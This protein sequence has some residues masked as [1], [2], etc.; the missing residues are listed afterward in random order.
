MLPLLIL[1]FGP[2]GVGKST[3]LQYLR[4]I[5]PPTYAILGSEHKQKYFYPINRN[6]HT[7]RD[8]KNCACE[9]T[10]LTGY[11]SNHSKQV[12]IMEGCNVLPK[13]LKAD[14]AIFLTCE[15]E[16]L[17][18]RRYNRET[19]RSINELRNRLSQQKKLREQMINSLN[20]LH[21]PVMN[22]YTEHQSID[23][24]GQKLINLIKSY[25]LKS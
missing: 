24:L 11:F 12:I 6:E 4:T 1:I 5:V 14:L 2:Q 18:K 16:T 8:M 25:I 23:I 15:D 13:K 20:T 7:T 19:N 22:L 10:Y 21:I 3:I 17:I 9:F